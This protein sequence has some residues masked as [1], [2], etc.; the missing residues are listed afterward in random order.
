MK[1]E[2]SDKITNR[3]KAIARALLAYEMNMSVLEYEMIQS[4]K[5]G[6]T[7]KILVT[8]KTK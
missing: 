4:V 6:T 8:R 7:P 3:R 5:S 2:H 1:E